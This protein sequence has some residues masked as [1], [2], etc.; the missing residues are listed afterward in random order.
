MSD[1]TT[2]MSDQ[3]SD[4]G[5]IG[6]GT[7]SLRC[8]HSTQV[9]CVQVTGTRHGTHTKTAEPMLGKHDSGSRRQST[10]LHSNVSQTA[11]RQTCRRHLQP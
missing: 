7:L 10:H 5:W 3:R 1:Q 11:V 6:R 8:L 4:R 2:D 9:H